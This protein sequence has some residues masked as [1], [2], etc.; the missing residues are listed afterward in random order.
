MLRMVGG[1]VV[2]HVHDLIRQ[3]ATSRKA[4]LSPCSLA[5]DL[6]GCGRLRESGIEVVLEDR[7]A[8]FQLVLRRERAGG[9]V[10]TVRKERSMGGAAERGEGEMPMCFW[11]AGF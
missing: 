2:A 9:I 8:P 7:F 11:V 3:L 10:S 4:G 6:C 5:K 1:V